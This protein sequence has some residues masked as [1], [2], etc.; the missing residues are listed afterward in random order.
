MTEEWRS[1]RKYLNKTETSAPQRQGSA[2]VWM[3]E[4]NRVHRV[5]FQS[6]AF[7]SL[8]PSAWSSVTDKAGHQR[9]HRGL[10]HFHSPV[11]WKRLRIEAIEP[12]GAEWTPTS[13]V[14][15]PRTPAFLL[16]FSFTLST[17][18][19][20]DLCHF[21]LWLIKEKWTRSDRLGVVYIPEDCKSCFNIPDFLERNRVS[22]PWRL[23]GDFYCWSRT[24]LLE[25]K[26]SRC[27]LCV[28]GSEC[29]WSGTL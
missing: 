10:F 27:L 1:R 19:L 2:H 6:W 7:I 26:L 8:H 16:H 24:G 11:W 9:S 3:T 29:V 14:W 17:K 18:A 5:T 15:T 28:C 23:K 12:P 4:E 21:V 25:L 22:F 20:F 13:S